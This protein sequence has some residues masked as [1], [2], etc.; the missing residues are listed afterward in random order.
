MDT[1]SLSARWCALTSSDPSDC[2]PKLV[3][4]PPPERTP[5]DIATLVFTWLLLTFG[6][7]ASA[8]VVQLFAY[9]V[10]PS[11]RLVDREYKHT[12]LSTL[13]VVLAAAI[14]TVYI[15]VWKFWDEREAAILPMQDASIGL[16]FGGILLVGMVVVL[17]F[18]IIWSIPAWFGKDGHG[19]RKDGDVRGLDKHAGKSM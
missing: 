13:N 19:T 2:F 12:I 7:I 18:R 4:T 10:F 3:I 14:P 11:L 9:Y 17:G 6:S 16:L 5:A 15:L 1:N 8:V